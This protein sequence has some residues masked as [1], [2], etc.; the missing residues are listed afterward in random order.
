MTGVTHQKWWG[1]GEEGVA[2][3]YRDKPRM[4]PFVMDKI[5][6]DLSV[7]GTPPP[8]FEDITVPASELP[9]DLA[10]I[11]RGA[12]GEQHVTTEDLDRVVHTYGKG[13]VDLVRIR[14]GHLPRVPDAVVYPADEDQVRAVVDAVVAADAVLIPFGGGSNIS[15]SLTPPAEENRTVVSLDLGRMNLV[16]E[17]DEDAGLA[18]VQAGALGPD[19][20]EQLTARGW[21]MGHQPDSFKH[22][23][24]GGWIAT[25][26]SGMQ[27][28][29][30]GDIADITRG[31]RVVLPGKVV[32]LRPL[33]SYSSGPSVREMILG[34]EGRLGVIT[35]A[36]VN[37]HR[38][39]ENR[40]II[41]YLF[42]NWGSAIQAM[43][44]ISVSDASPSVTRVSDAAET[45]FSFSTQ[46]ESQ[47]AKKKIQDGL[48][49]FLDKRGWDLDKVCL[50]Y[51]GYEGGAARIRA[52]KSVVGKIVR[53]HGGIKL[54]AGPGTLY[55]QKKFDTPYIR[56]F[57]LD[58]GALA[59]VSETAMPW[60]RLMEVYHHTMRAA[61]GAF[62][63]LGVRGYVMCHLSHSYHS[64][65]CLY[66]TF[67]FV[68]ASP[69]MD[70]Q[71][72]Q[73]WVVKSAIQ[74]SFVDHGGT[75][76]HHHGVGTDHAPWL[77][78]DISPAGVDMQVALLQGVDPGRHL[79]PGTILPSD[80]EW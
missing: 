75:I 78:E 19:L 52:E 5:G 46:K 36:W 31:M 65:A 4:A 76:S 50:S 20:E 66:F 67:A 11:L 25:R 33:P 74:Q 64:G 63:D 3:N 17:I 1:W 48:F 49:G 60:S 68:S 57:L 59:D 37:V 28:D 58:I 8:S 21:T 73:Y 62:E 55:D 42:P 79:N 41:A 44:A 30:Y 43:H 38:L 77:E 47:G 15:G 24:L 80:R 27:S 22:S 7:P 14:A 10:Q 45:S 23:T 71:L 16:R 6:I 56:D 54:G 26:S 2:F 53:Q 35:E 69:E 40:E 61:K 13:L 72:R 9:E 29:K 34:S 70:E 39:P 18:R 51:V 32:N 12:V